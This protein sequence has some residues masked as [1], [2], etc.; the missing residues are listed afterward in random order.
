MIRRL[1]ETII[2]SHISLYACLWSVTLGSSTCSSGQ[3]R[4]IAISSKYHQF[5]TSWEDWE[6]QERRYLLEAAVE[7]LKQVLFCVVCCLWGSCAHIIC[8]CCCM[9]QD[10]SASNISIIFIWFYFC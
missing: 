7:E 4:T 3:K 1:D 2:C 6:P 5:D 9:L 8:G 10:I